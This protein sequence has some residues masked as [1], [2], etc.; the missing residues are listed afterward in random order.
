MRAPPLLFRPEADYQLPIIFAGGPP[1][2]LKK[3]KLWKTLGI[4]RNRN[5]FELQTTWW[6]ARVR[7][8]NFEV[9]VAKHIFLFSRGLG[10]P[11]LFAA[12]R[13]AKIIDN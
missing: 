3:K 13:A 5:I 6:L 2:P 9:E 8:E 7:S 1:D 4:P 10:V 12:L 11:Q